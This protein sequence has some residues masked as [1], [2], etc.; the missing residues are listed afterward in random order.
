MIQVENCISE[1]RPI[2][3]LG[4][5]N[6]ILA[7]F[8]EDSELFLAVEVRVDLMAVYQE[9]IPIREHPELKSLFNRRTYRFKPT[10]VRDFTDFLLD[11]VVQS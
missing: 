8:E 10:N 1:C 11:C 3:Q 7:L 5:S 9:V 6:A 2:L 4:K